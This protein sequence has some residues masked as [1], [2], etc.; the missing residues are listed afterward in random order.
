M[1]ANQTVQPILRLLQLWQDFQQVQVSVER[2]GDILNIPPERV[3]AISAVPPRPRGAIEVKHV[4]FRYRPGGPEVLKRMSVPIRADEVVGIV[5]PS[6]SGK[7]TLTKLIQRLYI[8]EEGQITLDGVD[9][10]QVDPAWLRSYGTINARVTHVAR[11]AIPQPEAEQTEKNSAKP[12]RS[13]QSGTAQR[14]QNLVFPVTLKPE[15]TLIGIDGRNIP[16]QAAWRRRSRSGQAA[17]AF[18]N[19]FSRRSC[20]SAPKGCGS[21]NACCGYA[22]RRRGSGVR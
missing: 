10:S 19:I 4:L 16:L 1:I 22:D 18:W 21:D 15:T 6:G 8:P 20:R 5:G 11:D 3:H 12:T 13:T 7:S 14:T 2:L 9:L 17:G